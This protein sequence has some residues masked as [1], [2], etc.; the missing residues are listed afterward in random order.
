MKS[1]TRKH[2]VG[3]ILIGAALLTAGAVVQAA[4]QKV[5]GGTACDGLI[6]ASDTGGEG[7]YHSYSGL[8]NIASDEGDRYA[9]CP[10]IRTNYTNTKGLLELNVAASTNGTAITCIAIS[11]TQF[12]SIKQSIAKSS[13]TSGTSVIAYGTS[14]NQSPT[15]GYYDVQCDLPYNST[16]NSVEY[17]EP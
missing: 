16:L 4:S 17:S 3:G 6:P 10:L 2:W 14:L 9:N 11:A 13:K 7:L 15:L 8:Q 12:G 1:N 5:L